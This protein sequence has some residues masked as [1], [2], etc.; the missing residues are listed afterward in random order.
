MV[1]IVSSGDGQMVVL[2]WMEFSVFLGG[3]K[4]TRPG[5]V[6]P[7]VYS[8]AQIVQNLSIIFPPRR[9]A[10]RRRSCISHC[11]RSYCGSEGTVTNLM[12]YTFPWN[13]PYGLSGIDPK[14]QGSNLDLSKF[15]CFFCRATLGGS[16]SQ[17]AMV[18]QIIPSHRSVWHGLLLLLLRHFSFP[19]CKSFPVGDCTEGEVNE[20]EEAFPGQLFLCSMV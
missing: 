6:Q 10:R 3:S 11:H 8:L 18:T 20:E 4:C 17:V 7:G 15:L 14:I 13:I 12:I 5:E 1:L 2:A 19:P 16:L 9:V